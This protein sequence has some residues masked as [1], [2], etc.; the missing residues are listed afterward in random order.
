MNYYEIIVSSCST[1]EG[2]T[3]CKS[4][5]GQ[6]VEEIQVDER[7][8]VKVNEIPQ[9]NCKVQPESLLPLELRI[10]FYCLCM[11]RLGSAAKI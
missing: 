1:E 11:G 4:H 7:T 3:L 9:T 5:Y 6:V 2:E 8:H 10:A